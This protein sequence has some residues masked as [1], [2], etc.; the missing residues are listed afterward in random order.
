MSS[1][2]DLDFA[3]KSLRKSPGFAAVAIVTLALGLG[4]NAA[5][6]NELVV[7]HVNS[8]GAYPHGAAPTILQSNDLVN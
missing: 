6:W 7:A 8:V 3:W 4:L 5:V 1:R 2:D